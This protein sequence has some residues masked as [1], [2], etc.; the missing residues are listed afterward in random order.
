MSNYGLKIF[1]TIGNSSLIV[2]NLAQIISSGTTTMPNVLN[3]DDTYG[4]DIDLP[5]DYDIDNADLGMIVQI[6]DFNYRVVLREFTYAT[7]KY[8]CIFY[9]DDNYTYYEKNIDTGEMT[10]WT[11]GDRTAYDITEWNPLIK[12]SLTAGWDKSGSTSRSMRIFAAVHYGFLQI[13]GGS[14]ST[15]TLY[16]RDTTQTVNAQTGYILSETQGS[17]LQSYS[18]ISDIS[19]KYIAAV[20]TNCNIYRVHYPSGATQIGSLVASHTGFERGGE[21]QVSGTW[22]CPLTNLTP[23]DAIC[24]V[25][26]VWCYFRDAGWGAGNKAFA[27]IYIT[28][29]SQD[30]C[31]LESN[32][33]TIY[34]Y[35]TATELTEGGNYATVTLSWGNSSKEVKATGVKYT[36][37]AYSAKSVA[38]MGDNGVSEVDYMIYMKKYR[39]D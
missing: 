23:G 31:T 16:G 2:P 20:I 12:I 32:T 19:Y 9:A 26:N 15:T 11:P 27:I 5:G 30:W 18:I 33:W 39:G 14:A 35:I 36:P 38:T 37:L 28:T 24:I 22:A 3:G 7:N 29:V 10:V 1:D 4:V 8:W 21:A 34:R 17:T 13:S 6:R 25:M